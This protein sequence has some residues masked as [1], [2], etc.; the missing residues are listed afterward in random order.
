MLGARIVV[1]QSS[2]VNE[3]HLLTPKYLVYSNRLVKK[4][5]RLGDDNIMVLPTVP[6]SECNIM[7]LAAACPNTLCFSLFNAF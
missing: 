6:F 3:T 7:G 1:D 4:I 2:L 5:F